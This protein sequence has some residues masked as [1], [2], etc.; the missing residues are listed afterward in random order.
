MVRKVKTIH[1][2]MGLGLCAVFIIA[3]VVRLYPVLKSPEQYR[4]G[5]G[6]FGDS[7]AYHYIGYNVYSGNGF[8]ATNDGTAFGTNYPK[9]DIW[10]EPAIT[11]GPGY[12]IFLAAVYKFF[13]N[14][15]DMKHVKRWKHNWQKV[16][17]AQCVVDAFTCLLVFFLVRFI[18]SHSYLPALIA[19][20]IY[21]FSFYNI[22]Y[23]WEILSE[24]IAAF[25]L[26][27][28]LLLC[29]A[30]V[31]NEGKMWHVF[32]GMGIGLV[33]LVRP[34]YILFLAVFSGYIFAINR[35]EFIGV[36][37]KIGLIV[38]G[39][40]VIILPWTARNYLV[41][42]QLI[43]NNVGG[44]GYSLY[45]GT[46]ETKDNWKDWRKF[47]EE[48]FYD[49][50]EKAKAYM[51]TEENTRYYSSGSIKIQRSEKEFT[52][53]A[54]KRIKRDPMR[55]IKV[56]ITSAPRLWYQNHIQMY[57]KKE[58]SGK[59]FIFYFIAGA[60]ALFT[61]RREERKL[62][63]PLWLAFCYLTLLFMPLHIE[64]RYGVPLMPAIICLAGMGLGNLMIV[65]KKQ[66]LPA[67]HGK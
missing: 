54:L 20:I 38:L 65:I 59:W 51:L 60:I 49:K 1:F 22:F 53:M 16:R 37:K 50:E 24:S 63:S 21:C 5:I 13:G 3:L 44:I 66:L 40:A 17:I 45:L 47:P 28:A 39:T 23:S 6:V 27:F 18:S 34:E 35:H 46:F 43:I 33:T 57:E 2:W 26:T 29:V 67:K 56:W 11:R 31:K 9:K 52:K 64:A 32:S 7:F 25:L 58:P 4:S 12:P 15:E 10:Y 8:S 14:A 48:V 62:M 41:F 55:C 19:S 61:A 36:A 30:A 42:R